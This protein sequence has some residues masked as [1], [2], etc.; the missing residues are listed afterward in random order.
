MYH[1]KK[2]KSKCLKD[3]AFVMQ[4]RIAVSHIFSRTLAKK[5]AFM[6]HHPYLIRHSQIPDE[7]VDVSSRRESVGS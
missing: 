7:S 6:F 4:H 1:V 3:R 5:L 2:S